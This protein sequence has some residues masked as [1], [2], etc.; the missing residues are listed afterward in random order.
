MSP[1]LTSRTSSPRGLTPDAPSPRARARHRGAVPALA[2]AVLLVPLLAAC[3]SDDDSDA[4]SSGG[5]DTKKTQLTVLAASSLTDVFAQA[6]KAYENEHPGTTIRVSP[7][8]SQELAAQV[9][10]GFPPTSW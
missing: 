7:A 5:G 9:R 1:A 3:G 10:N 6:K 8:G 2:A 4:S